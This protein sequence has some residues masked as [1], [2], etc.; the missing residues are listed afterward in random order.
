M[1]NTEKRLIL[2][3]ALSVVVIIL[4]QAYMRQ[5]S[6]PYH[7]VVG[8]DTVSNYEARVQTMSPVLEQVHEDVNKETISYD[9]VVLSNNVI[10]IGVTGFGATVNEILLKNY[11]SK[12]GEPYPLLL[13]RQGQPMLFKTVFTQSQLYGEWGLEYNDQY[14]VRYKRIGDGLS[15]SKTITLDKNSNFITLD[16]VI[17][18]ETDEPQVTQYRLY[19]GSLYT[20][21]SHIDSR[22]VGADILI[23]DKV[24]RKRISGKTMNEGE[25]I[26][27]TPAWVSTRGRY[28]SFLMKPEQDAQSAFVQSP[29]KNNLCA[30]VVSYPVRL[31]PQGVVKHVFHVYAGPNDLKAMMSLDPTSKDIINYGIFHGIG[32]ILFNGLRMLYGWT[33]NYG[34]SIIL[35]A[36]IISLVMLPL[37][38]KSLHSMKEMQK[39]QPETELIRK[40]YSDNPQKMNKEIMELYKKHK[41]N[42]IGGCLP[43]LLQIPI[44]FSLYQVL[45]RSVELKGANFLWIKDLA[46]PDAAF[47][48][49]GVLQNLPFLGG[50]I[51]ILPILMA[52]AM[53]L[54]QRLS[55]GGAKKMSDQQRLMAGIMPIMFGVIFYNMPSGLV[56]YWFV[57]TI[58]MLVIQEVVSKSRLAAQVV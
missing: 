19:G 17:T 53:A 49:P 34:V 31:M 20:V 1:M 48:L 28:F 39:I 42:P 43:M 26:P 15:V 5:F 44:F 38:R 52:V 22:Y 12:D 29:N 46:E 45:L 21:S 25:S 8:H 40:Q 6:K 41:V 2:A 7:H 36:L 35:L 57:N 33:N 18:N 32:R 30:G 23:G 47:T 56:L 16:I 54:Q 9:T 37:T 51:N 4:Y 58:F 13:N 14:T 55:Q 3:V 24:I 11:A 10:Q 27:G 50:H